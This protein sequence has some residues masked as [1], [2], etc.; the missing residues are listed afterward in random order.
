[1]KHPWITQYLIGLAVLVALGSSRAYAQF[2]IDPDHYETREP[3]PQQSKTNS[4][5]QAAKI[6]YEGNFTLAYTL[7]CNGQSLPPGK[8]SV[9]LDSD[10]RT[11]RL[12]LNRNGQVLK[13]QGIPRRQNRY[14][15]PDALVVERNGGLHQ[16]SLIHVAQLAL[17]FDAYL[18]QPSGKQQGGAKLRKFETVALI[19]AHPRQSHVKQ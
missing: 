19:L 3:E 1:M 15:R 9:S 16:L 10:E 6:H 13:I 5:A 2:E 11:A 12:A 18:K 8:Y 7:Q 4:P 14:R 17:I